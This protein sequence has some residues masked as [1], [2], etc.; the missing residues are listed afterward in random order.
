MEEKVL[1][2]ICSKN[3]AISYDI[4]MMNII[5]EEAQAYFAG[6][7]DIDKTVRIIQ[8]RCTTYM[9]ESK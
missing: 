4:E 8:K 6:K 3:K 9:S 2:I 1:D 5:D 7:K